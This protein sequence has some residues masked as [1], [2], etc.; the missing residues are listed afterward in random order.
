M[1]A[2]QISL[3]AYLGGARSISQNWTIEM[4]GGGTFH[5][6]EHP[7]KNTSAVSFR[8]Y[9]SWFWGD[10]EYWPFSGEKGKIYQFL[11]LDK[12]IFDWLLIGLETEDIQLIGSF[13][14]SFW[15]L[16]GHLF[17]PFGKLNVQIALV[18]SW[19]REEGEPLSKTSYRLYLHI[20]P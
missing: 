14:D 16:G 7:E 20:E 17:V 9:S 2:E 12:K 18:Q 5:P 6:E 3:W 8:G 4:L 13:K 19:Y 15:S 10:I 11:Q 1:S